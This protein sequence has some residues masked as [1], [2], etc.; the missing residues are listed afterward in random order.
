MTVAVAEEVCCVRRKETRYEEEMAEIGCAVGND[1]LGADG[2]LPGKNQGVEGD[3][4][5]LSLMVAFLIAAT[6]EVPGLATAAVA[7]AA[8]ALA[9][10]KNPLGDWHGFLVVK[11]VAEVGSSAETCAAEALPVVAIA[12][13]P[14]VSG[15]QSAGQERDP[16]GVE[17]VAGAPA[18]AAD[19][20]TDA[21]ADV[22][23]AVD[24]D[25][26]VSGAALVAAAAALA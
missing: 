12:V 9:P 23:G 2:A 13:V 21:E 26:R 14:D 8:Q 11:V 25:S 19:V 6:A 3:R 16:E 7:V 17:E 15:I 1:D 4:R 24:R 5:T 20:N 18:A 10:L 22:D